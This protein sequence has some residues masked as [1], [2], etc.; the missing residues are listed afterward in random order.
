MCGDK[1]M[2]GDQIFVVIKI[3]VTKFVGWLKGVSTTTRFMEIETGPILI[4]CKLDLNN[5]QILIK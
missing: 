1:K 3:L 2:C 5:N 4:T